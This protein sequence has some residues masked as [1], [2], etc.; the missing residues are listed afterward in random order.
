MKRLRRKL[1][2][3]ADSP[4]YIFPE[5]RRSPASMSE[6]QGMAEPGLAAVTG[7]FSYTGGYVARRL[8]DRGLP[9]RTLRG[10]AAHPALPETFLD[11]AALRSE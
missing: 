3:D 9:V 1:G 7:A 4:R 2:E 8:L 5:P 10:V 11:S 6:P